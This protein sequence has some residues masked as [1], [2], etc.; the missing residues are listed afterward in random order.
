MRVIALFCLIFSALPLRAEV[1]VFA[2]ASLRGALD[3]VNARFDG[4]VIVSYASSAALA[5][6]IAQGAPAD[7]FLS[8]SPEWV[9]FLKDDPFVELMNVTDILSNQLVLIAS[10]TAQATNIQDLPSALSGRNLALALTTAVPAGIYAREALETMG[11][12]PQIAPHSVETDNVRA[13]LALVALGEVDYGIVY[14]T[15]ALTQKNLRVLDVIAADTHQPIRYVAAQIG[16][17]ADAARYFQ[18]LSDPTAQAIFMAHGF[19]LPEA[20]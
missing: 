12:W 19:A 5:R 3:E 1:T 4:K 7:V 17:G 6:Q 11:L 20:E 16:T 15:D 10:E 18:F 13:A 9:A 14:Q 8:A 2:A